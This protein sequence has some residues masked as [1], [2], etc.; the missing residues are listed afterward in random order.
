MTDVVVATFNLHWGRGLRW[1]GYKPFEV[2]PAC[3][4]L[5][6]DVLVLQESFAPDG[7]E[8]QHDAIAR[9]L[10]Y[11]VVAESL[12]RA[13]ERPRPAVVDRPD[14]HRR[15]GT[16]DW[17]LAVLSR[18]P[19]EGAKITP[20]PQ[21]HVDPAAR[22]IIR[23]DVTVDGRTLAVH[24][25]HLPHLEFGVHRIRHAFREAIGPAEGA[26]VLLGD[27]NMWGW[28]ISAMAP[29]GWRRV[30][31]G[32]TFPTPYPHS[33]IDHLLVTPG[34]EVLQS[35]VVPERGSDHRPVRAR[36]RLR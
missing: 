24:G 26:G 5:D 12:G 28:T 17:C 3:E 33:R 30:G 29:P 34:V 7:A 19:V 35:E 2:V 9:A 27:M 32:R 31:R 14:P 22:A 16:G 10:G 15:K 13:S 23:V 20:L 11:E 8:A 6:A 4:R 21:L 18:L 25:T 1:L 36:L